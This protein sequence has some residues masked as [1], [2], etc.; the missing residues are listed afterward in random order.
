MY[1][2]NRNKVSSVFSVELIKVGL[3]LEVVCVNV[4][5]FGCGIGSYVVIH[6][7]YFESV[8]LVGKRLHALL[9]DFSM[10]RGTCRNGY[11]LVA[12]SVAVI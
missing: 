10:R 11:C 3:M 4:A 9:K 1:L 8:A 2:G 12:G 6:Y 7:F 5:A